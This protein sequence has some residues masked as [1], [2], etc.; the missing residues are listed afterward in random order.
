MGEPSP[1][2]NGG[3]EDVVEGGE[4]TG[5]LARQAGY[6]GD[7]AP[8][9]VRGVQVLDRN[10]WRL[11]YRF[12]YLSN[13]GNRSGT[14]RES[15]QS[16]RDQ[17]FDVV[18][19]DLQ[20]QRHLV[21]LLYAP[22]DRLT[23]VAE[24]PILDRRMKHRAP[25]G[26]SYET[27]MTG[28]G[29]LELAARARFMRKGG[30][31]W[32]MQIGFGFPTGSIRENDATPLGK[33]RLPY[34]MQP[35]TGTYSFRPKLTYLGRLEEHSWGA[36][37]AFAMPLN[38]NTRDWKPGNAFEAN[39]WY[40]HTWFGWVDTSLRV[41]WLDWGNLRGRDDKLDPT[42]QPANDARKY[43]GARLDLGPGLRIGPPHRKGPS[44][45][46]DAS[47]P[48]YQT[49]DGPQIEHDWRMSAAAAWLF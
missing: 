44:L 37:M 35:G 6:L 45:A 42:L 43:G 27:H 11:A 28:V 9:S 20:T 22:I 18:T 34:S 5:G 25:D 31:A 39:G 33:Q 1:G 49:L 3:E 15:E 23:L 14:G 48:V 2:A 38:E 21:E 47:W 29:D 36:Q 13:N 4:E 30:Q 10:E 8:L 16:V 7:T 26:T 32:N 17:G 12:D 24:L 40:T 46:F 19:Y 41:A